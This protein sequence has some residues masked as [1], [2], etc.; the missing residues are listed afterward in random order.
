VSVDYRSYPVLFVDDEPQNLVTFRYALAEDFDVL[1]VGSGEEALRLMAGRAVA[2]LIADQRMPGMTGVELCSEARR[3]WPDM[4]RIIITAYADLHAAISAINDGKVSRYMV[5]P[6][7]NEELADILRTAI[8]FVHLQETMRDMELRLLSSGQRKVA[9]AAQDELLHE[10]ANPITAAR[11]ALGEAQGEA[12]AALKA[13]QRGSSDGA[14]RSLQLLLA[15]QQDAGAALQQLA[16]I[17]DR[18][19][20]QGRRQEEPERCEAARVVD[21]TIRILRREVERHASLTVVLE[22]APEIAVSASVLGQIVL[23][24]LTN[25]SQAIATTGLP[26][27]RILVELSE[28]PGIAR[29]RVR[30]TGPGVPTGQLEEIFEPYFTTKDDGS[31]LGLSITRELARGAGGKVSVRNMADGGCEFEVL[32]PVIAADHI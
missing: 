8:E 32:L 7:R 11:L 18:M 22:S 12:T 5:K 24:L 16:D 14:E 27:G 19:R 17:C 3:R 1:T 25:A 29:L 31:G 26:G 23:N 10:V 20:P 28:A 15:A 13:L 4:V 30:D 6:W 21:A 9:I 2:V